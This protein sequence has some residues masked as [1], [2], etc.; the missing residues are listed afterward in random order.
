MKQL[1]DF[2]GSERGRAAHIAAHL[3]VAPAYLSQMAS[4]LRPVR[5]DLAPAIERLSGLTVRRWHLRPTDWHRIWP[6]LVGTDGA[7]RPPIPAEQQEAV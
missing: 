7:P 6:E 3:R 4:G 1:S 5:A 2:L